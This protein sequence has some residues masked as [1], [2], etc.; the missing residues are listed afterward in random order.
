MPSASGRELAESWTSGGHAAWLWRLVASAAACGLAL[1]VLVNEHVPMGNR[2]S[3]SGADEVG[4]GW[5]TPATGGALARM[6]LGRNVFGVFR[7][8]AFEWTN[9][10]A[11]PSTSGSFSL[12]M[13]NSL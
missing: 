8:A 3:E 9:R 5:G 13:T 10:N 1:L 12:R 4:G 7:G 2:G 6:N 11:S